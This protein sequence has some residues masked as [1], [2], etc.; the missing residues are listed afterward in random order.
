MSVDYCDK[1]ETKYLAVEKSAW[2]FYFCLA[3]TPLSVSWPISVVSHPEVWACSDV[4][5]DNIEEAE[6]A[7]D[8]S[9]DR[10]ANQKQIKRVHDKVFPNTEYDFSAS[11]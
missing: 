4:A 3:Y 10:I 8:E 5:D 9:A 7:L 6:S 11:L 1:G 2:N